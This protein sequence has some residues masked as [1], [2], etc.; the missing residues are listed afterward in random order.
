MVDIAIIDSSFHW[1][2]TP[3]LK[4]SLSQRDT[5]IIY[6]KLLNSMILADQYYIIHRKKMTPS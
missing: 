6:K 3:I 2:W 5:F 1:H 4:F